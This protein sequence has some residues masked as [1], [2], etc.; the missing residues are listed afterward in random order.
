MG[1]EV[2][3]V[4]HAA[5][6][7]GEIVSGV[8][9]KCL[10]VDN[11]STNDGARVQQWDCKGQAG[12]K[13]EMTRTD[14]GA[15]QIINSN[16]GKCLEV[17]DARTDNGAPVQQ[18]ACTDAKAQRWEAAK[19]PGTDYYYTLKNVNSGKLLEIDNA[20]LA[21]GA[22]AQQ[23]ADNGQRAAKWLLPPLKKYSPG[24]PLYAVTKDGSLESW[25]VF[26]STS[27]RLVSNWDFTAAVQ[28]DHDKDGRAEGL[29][30]RDAEGNLAYTNDALDDDVDLGDGW[31]QYDLLFSPGDLGGTKASELL[32][33]DTSG[34]LWLIRGNLDGSLGERIRLGG[35]W[36]AYTQVTGL[37]DLTADGNPDIVAA[38]KDGVLWLYP[39]TGNYRAPFGD[40]IRV[41]GGWGQFN[42]LAFVSDA[43]IDGRSDLIARDGAGGLWLYESTGKADSPF[44]PRR[45]FLDETKNWSGYRALF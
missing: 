27:S 21:N 6:Q 43:G 3:A 5:D 14:D 7:A 23:W 9:G 24:F 13:W 34:V 44:K 29:Y 12:S 10:E 26:T 35:G 2:P 38:D 39:G 22:R 20:S 40:R 19:F 28:V 25:N 18:S 37:G 36:G 4:S 11:S 32:A 15:L 1:V 42:L 17:A 41:G 33:R 8:S 30:T 45:K 31:N 16:S